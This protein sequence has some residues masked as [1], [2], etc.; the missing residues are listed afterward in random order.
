[1]TQ[2]L[3]LDTLFYRG[4]SAGGI[5]SECRM[6]NCPQK[7]QQ[8]QRVQYH[9]RSKNPLCPYET[10]CFATTGNTCGGTNY[11]S[12]TCQHISTMKTRMSVTASIRMIVLLS[13]ISWTYTLQTTSVDIPNIFNSFRTHPSLPSILLQL[14]TV[15][16]TKTT[17][18]A[19]VHPQKKR[20]QLDGMKECTFAIP[21]RSTTYHRSISSSNNDVGGYDPSEGI[22][23]SERIKEKS[24]VGNP[25]QVQTLEK[26]FSVT[27]ILKELAA[28]QQQGPQ[29]YCILGTRHCSY[30]HQQIIE[31]LYVAFSFLIRS[32]L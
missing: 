21:P 7:Q 9:Q 8:Q 16:A 23:V 30:L 6:V 1:M 17:M 3:Q 2:M 24:N 18:S 22:N 19:F 10:Y 27:S 5:E 25:Q 20:M 32:D 11:T 12:P 29:K 13:I 26:E 31:L 14:P 4:D 15:Q 28:I